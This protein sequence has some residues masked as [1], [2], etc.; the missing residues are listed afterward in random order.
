MATK[1]IDEEVL[2]VM[3]KEKKYKNTDLIPCR[4]IVSGGLYIEGNRSK[5]LY[6]WADYGD[7]VEIEYQDL[8]Y[9]VR[10]RANKDIY[11]PRIIIEDEEFVKQNKSL[12]ELYNSLYSTKDIRDI[13]ELPVN[14]MMAEIKKLPEGVKNSVKGIASTMI[15]AHQLD[16]VQKIKALDEFFG[17][18]MLLTL[19]QE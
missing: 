1:K 14:R 19:V 9:M 15:D 16:S 12:E 8:L 13:I 3:E 5:I 6:S 11:L 17:T 4:S 2:E 7:V 18:Q 10:T